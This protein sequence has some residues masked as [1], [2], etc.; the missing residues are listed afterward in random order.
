MRSVERCKEHFQGDRCKKELNHA[1]SVNPNVD[2]L[3]RGNFTV[4]QGSGE[5]Q[6]PLVRTTMKH[7]RNRIANRVVR[8]LPTVQNVRAPLRKLVIAQCD[9]LV[10]HFRG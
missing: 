9:Q 2:E 4:W 10:K 5:T 1:L 3:H 6:E 7:K 8:H